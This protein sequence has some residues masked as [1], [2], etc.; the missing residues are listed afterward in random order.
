MAK[1]RIPIKTLQG[2]Y[3]DGVVLYAADINKI[4]DVLRAGINKNKFDLDKILLGSES[5]NV[6]YSL[7]ALNSL[8]AVVGDYA[9]VYLNNELEDSL[10]L[11]IYN[12]NGQWEKVKKVSLLDLYLDLQNFEAMPK[13]IITTDTEPEGVDFYIK[14]EI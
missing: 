5:D 10:D 3:V 7:N 14:I 4:I 13:I 2:D 1:E 8:D 9:F 11:M 12:T 6:V